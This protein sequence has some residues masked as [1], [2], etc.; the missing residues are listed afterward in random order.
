VQ[1]RARQ[2]AIR[3]REEAA[4]RK[5][6][7]KCV[8][9]CLTDNRRLKDLRDTK[10]LSFGADAEEGEED[11]SA[12]PKKKKSVA[13]PDCAWPSVEHHSSPESDSRYSG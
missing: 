8:S 2:V 3:E 1:Q 4:R 5:G 12:A 10:L 7:K 11:V 6:A 9:P 13:R